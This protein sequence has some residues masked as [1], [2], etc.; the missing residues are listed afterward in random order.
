MS[1]PERTPAENL[2]DCFLIETHEKK[3]AQIALQHT[4]DPVIRDELIDQISKHNAEIDSILLEHLANQA[5]GQS[6]I[7]DLPEAA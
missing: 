2:R 3:M 7:L 4:V 5:L 6:G 1:T